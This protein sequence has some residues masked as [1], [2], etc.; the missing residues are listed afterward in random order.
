VGRRPAAVAGWS[1]ELGRGDMAE[2]SKRLTLPDP[3]ARKT[4][5]P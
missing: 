1:G 3:K 2:A 4:A 5:R